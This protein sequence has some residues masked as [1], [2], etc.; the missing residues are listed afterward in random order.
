MK[1]ILGIII[2][3]IIVAAA[4][5]ACGGKQGGLD[6]ELAKYVEL[7]SVT[8]YYNGEK[9]T[10]DLPYFLGG[11]DSVLVRNENREVDQFA[12]RIKNSSK[13]E[14]YKVEASYVLTDGKWISLRLIGTS[15]SAPGEAAGEIWAT[16]YNVEDQTLVWAATRDFPHSDNFDAWL[17]HYVRDMYK[18]SDGSKVRVYNFNA[19]YLYYVE[20]AK[21]MAAVTFTELRDGGEMREAAME[22]DVT[23]GPEPYFN[24]AGMQTIGEMTFDADNGIPSI[25]A[26]AD[27][28]SDE[29][30]ITITY[31]DES[32][33]EPF[34]Q[35][36]AVGQ[37][38]PVFPS[39]FHKLDLKITYEAGNPFAGDYTKVYTFTDDRGFKNFVLKTDYWGEKDWESGFEIIS[40]I[41]AD[42]I[43]GAL[44]GTIRGHHGMREGQLLNL[45]PH[46]LFIAEEI[47]SQAHLT[48]NMSRPSKAYVYK[49]ANGRD[50]T[51]LVFIVKD[52][53]VISI[54][55][56]SSYEY[57]RYDERLGLARPLSS[58]NNKG[59][60]LEVNT[61]FSHKKTYDIGDVLPSYVDIDQLTGD[62][63]LI[64]VDIQVPR[65]VDS[66]PGAAEINKMI[67]NFSPYIIEIAEGLNRGDLGAL[68]QSDLIGYAGMYYNTYNYRNAAA[69]VVEA[70]GYLFQAGGSTSYLIIYYDC[71][72]GNI[73]TPRE[74]LE[75]CQITEERVL[76]ECADQNY[77]PSYPGYGNINSIYD[78]K[79]V[80]DE[81]GNL[82]LYT[83]LS[84]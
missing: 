21:L 40:Y 52:G 84:S 77:V 66:V 14:G 7:R 28:I 49:D 13:E 57:S 65:V 63:R 19:P 79:F 74:Y 24:A 71:D 4:L 26:S 50:S 43:D 75:K 67:S 1:R 55:T 69:L 78:V 59:S 64:R 3:L 45:Y 34:Y 61:A 33:S 82:I 53:I 81:D 83:E 72:T 56:A 25:E 11:E 22:I 62:D 58:K 60:G 38:D 8:G 16:N 68:I 44:I 39:I 51:D 41:G 18:E 17:Q 9:Y 30:A 20:N 27:W 23:D 46:D 73:M 80:L 76:E 35:M 48:I 32:S 31:W 47:N 42:T 15:D 54:D 29:Y 12:E 36:F 37:T 2:C 10:V 6:K 5:A 70:G